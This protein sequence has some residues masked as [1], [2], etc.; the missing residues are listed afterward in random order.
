MYN[1][2]GLFCYITTGAMNLLI[3][4]NCLFTGI[5]ESCGGTYIKQAPSKS[6]PVKSF[7]ISCAED[8]NTWTKLRKSGKPLVSP[9]VLLMGVLQQKLDLKS[10]SLV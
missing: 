10:N 7:I 2:F 6:W 5:I 9:E 1:F 8:K 3:K 4:C